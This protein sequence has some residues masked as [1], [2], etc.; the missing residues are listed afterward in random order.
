MFISISISIS[1]SSFSVP[2]RTRRGIKATQRSI[3]TQ[4]GGIYCKRQDGS[5]AERNTIVKLEK[6][7][8]IKRRGT[9][10]S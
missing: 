7:P 3:S 2:D 1:H 8:K 4:G 10:I 5:K 6:M 9:G